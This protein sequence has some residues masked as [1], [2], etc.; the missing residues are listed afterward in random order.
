MFLGW[1]LR[2]GSLV[3]PS[4]WGPGKESGSPGNDCIFSLTRAASFWDPCFCSPERPECGL[5]DCY[6]NVCLGTPWLSSRHASSLTTR[7]KWAYSLSLPSFPPPPRAP[8][9]R[10]WDLFRVTLCIPGCL[11]RQFTCFLFDWIRRLSAFSA[12]PCEDL[13]ITRRSCLA[14]Q[15]VYNLNCKGRQ[16]WRV[17]GLLPEWSALCNWTV[18]NGPNR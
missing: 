1:I 14:S 3:V 4:G 8:G 2:K 5:S 11:C 16:I 13:R 9:I 17:S 6:P 15:A 7:S 12:V 18:N 10:S